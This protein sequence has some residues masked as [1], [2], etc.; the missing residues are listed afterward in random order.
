MLPPWLIHK[1]RTVITM[2]SAVGMEALLAGKP[3][4]TLAPAF[5]ARSGM[6]RAVSLD[7]YEYVRCMI[8]DAEEYIPEHS[9]ICKFTSW[10]INDF[11]VSLSCATNGNSLVNR[12]RT[13]LNELKECK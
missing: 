7:D 9:A 5:Y 12:I 13:T 2:N 1:C 6:A 8:V 4:F 11:I 10:L 3:V